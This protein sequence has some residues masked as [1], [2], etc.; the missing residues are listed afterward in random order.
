MN[1]RI[2]LGILAFC[3]LVTGLVVANMFTMAMIGE[4]NRKRKNGET[5]S[6]IG[7]TPSKSLQ[8]V[9]EYKSLYPSG[10]LHVYARS[11]FGLAVV[12]I[13]V[14]AICIGIIR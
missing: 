13:V 5:V 2:I 12:G 7:F 11:A 1:I 8:I 3:A 6:Y 14:A 4:I 10:K 9:R